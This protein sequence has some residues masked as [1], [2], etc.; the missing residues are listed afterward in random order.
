M[1][2]EYII[3]NPSLVTKR[4]E[5]I[6]KIADGSIDEHL[7]DEG[8]IS[9]FQD[10]QLLFE[11]KSEHKNNIEHLFENLVEDLEKLL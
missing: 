10:N 2:I 4:K 8:K 7:G 3:Q 1:K 11:F 9:I 5:I 6:K